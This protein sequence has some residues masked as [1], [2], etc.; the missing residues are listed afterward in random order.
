VLLA[1][2]VVAGSPALQEGDLATALWFH[3][4]AHAAMTQVMG[5][6]TILGSPPFVLSASAA[7]A[8]WLLLRRAWR[9]CAL[10][11]VIVAGGMLLNV[12]VKRRLSMRS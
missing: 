2:A 1:A 4:H 9:T 8:G 10:L 12:T 11:V 6:I 5:A 3:D 7:L